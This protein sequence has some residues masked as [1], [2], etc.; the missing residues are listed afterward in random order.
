[1]FVPLDAG[2]LAEWVHRGALTA[3]PGYAAT[4]AFLAAFGLG[5]PDEEE[6]DLTL[7]SIA[8]LDGL[9]RHGVRLV[10]VA[11]T[12]AKAA[13]SAEPAEFGAVRGAHALVGASLVLEGGQGVGVVFATAGGFCFAGADGSV[14]NLSGSRFR[15]GEYSSGSACFSRRPGNHSVTFTLRK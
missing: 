9:L 5:A 3:G 10:A 11:E 12:S 14:A 2:G 13:E 8:S 6:T 15:P 1:M 7:L 4:P